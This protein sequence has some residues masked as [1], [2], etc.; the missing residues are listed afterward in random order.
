[1]QS[2]FLY[3]CNQRDN[4][5]K[6]CIEISL[7]LAKLQRFKSVLFLPELWRHNEDDGGEYD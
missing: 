5:I 7:I 1:M 2:Q 6:N 3:C 4:Q